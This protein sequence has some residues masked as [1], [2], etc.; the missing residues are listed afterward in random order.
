L[1]KEMMIIKVYAKRRF[2][3]SDNFMGEVLMM[4]DGFGVL[5]GDGAQAGKT[6]ALS[7]SCQVLTNIS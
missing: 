6:D 5:D 1:N 7:T 2:P 3:V 4:L